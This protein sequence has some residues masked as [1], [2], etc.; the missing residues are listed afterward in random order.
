[1]FPSFEF[2]RDRSKM[3][4][5]WFVE[6][7]LL[8][9]KRHIAYTTACCY[10]AQDVIR[11]SNQHVIVATMTTVGGMQKSAEACVCTCD[12]ATVRVADSI[13]CKNIIN[14][15]PL[16]EFSQFS[17][18]RH[19]NLPSRRVQVRDGTGSP[20]HGSP[21]HRISDFDRIRSGH[22]SVCQRRCLTRF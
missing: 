15:L 7:S 2:Q 16:A 9:L 18:R 3:W 20:G 13:P 17:E 21:G 6:I 10:T 4:D 19:Q 8:P 1:M 14:F 5:L 22:G 12:C 11:F